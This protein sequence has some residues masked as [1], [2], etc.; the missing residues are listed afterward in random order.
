MFPAC[1]VF[2]YFTAGAVCPYGICILWAHVRTAVASKN[3]FFDATAVKTR[4][5]HADDIRLTNAHTDT[6]KHTNRLRYE[7]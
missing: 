1:M 6:H 2:L 5:R 4:V 3:I 7:L